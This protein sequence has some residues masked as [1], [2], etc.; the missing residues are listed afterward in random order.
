RD[1]DSE[2]LRPLRPGDIAVLACVTTN[3][4]LLLSE[5]DA[6]GIEYSARGGALF[7]SH[8]IVRQYLLGLRALADR[9]DG[10]AR[11]ALLRPPFF[12]LDLADVLAKS[13]L[14][15]DDSRARERFAAAEACVRGL[16]A[17]RW[18]QS[19][20]ATARD[21]IERTA[22][23]RAVVTGR[24]GRQTLAALYEIAWELDR[25]A[26][27]DA[28]DYDQVTALVRAWAD[29]PVFLDAPESLGDDAVRVLSIHQAKGLEF[30]VVILWDGFQTLSDRGGGLWRVARD[31][32]GWALS[33]GALA[34]E[35]PLGGQLLE[36]EKQFGESERRRM[37]YVA[38]TRARDLLV[39]PTPKTK[40]DQLAYA[41]KALAADVAPEL[42]R[43]FKPFDPSM[44]PPDRSRP[45]LP[46]GVEADDDL[47]TQ[48]D[49]RVAERAQQSA[50]A[51][52]PVA[53]PIAVTTLAKSDG[54]ADEAPEAERERK[55]A[56]SR[57]GAEFGTVVHRALELVL[58]GAQAVVSAAV[59]VAATEAGA[60]QHP[61][62]LA[63]VERALATLRTA[64]LMSENGWRLSCE[65]P[66]YD[67]QP[68]ALL[69][70][71]IDL[72]AISDQ[73]VVVIDFKS[74]QPRD[75]D[76]AAVY[77]QYAEQL[78]LYGAAL[79]H[80]NRIGSRIVR[81]GLLLTATGQLRWLD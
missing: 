35:H 36:R 23:G 73:E 67:T 7:L 10:V 4:P 26:A 50:T 48:L 78:R 25:R 72:L 20:G 31:G 1:P 61:E 33:L 75:G 46:S 70:G 18:Q 74:D 56:G 42:V 11:A 43:R 29:S 6:L 22:L 54:G 16:R 9:D 71:L 57:Y 39:L 8:P 38:A 12:A 41:T 80:S 68:G 63:D 55:S 28:L 81:L 13:D 58:S 15:T 76:V 2:Q 47:Q 77:P 32:T 3:L 60:D 30:P 45:T 52:Q 27:V 64:G 40:S 19:P 65:H 51:A 69:I 49:E 34:V 59:A 17:R 37:Y 79:E 24:N 21:L 62:A 5:F 66:V 44:P 53:V 14:E